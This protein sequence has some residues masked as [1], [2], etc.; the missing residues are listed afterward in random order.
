MFIFS[1]SSR[2]R[3]LRGTDEWTEVGC[4]YYS[5]TRCCVKCW[6]CFQDNI[7]VIKVN[8]FKQNQKEIKNIP[9]FK[10]NQKEIKNIPKSNYTMS[11]QNT[12]SLISGE[13]TPSLVRKEMKPA[14][15]LNSWMPHSHSVR[16]NNTSTR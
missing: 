16:N 1:K 10:Q 13:T 2:V 5:C 8:D 12:V 11:T 4:C 9:D 3:S 15:E 14:K 6:S 7:D